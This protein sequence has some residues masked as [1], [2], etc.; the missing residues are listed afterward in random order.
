MAIPLIENANVPPKPRSPGAAP[1]GTNSNMH[2]EK[3]PTDH[4]PSTC[5]LCAV[6]NLEAFKIASALASLATH[7]PHTEQLGIKRIHIQQPNEK[8]LTPSRSNLSCGPEP[9][10]SSILTGAGEATAL[11]AGESTAGRVPTAGTRFLRLMTVFFIAT[12]RGTPCSL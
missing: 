11:G 1:N 2:C 7:P 9:D 8:P 3:T 5:P 6:Q 4:G 12:G 10:I